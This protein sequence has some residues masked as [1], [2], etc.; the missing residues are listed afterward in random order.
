MQTYRLSRLDL[1]KP[2]RESPADPEAASE[3]HVLLTDHPIRCVVIPETGC[4]GLAKAER[5]ERKCYHGTYE[6]ARGFLQKYDD[7]RGCMKS[8][9]QDLAAATKSED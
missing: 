1:H 8:G 3:R 7:R 9:I 5:G 4:E 6:F 2:F